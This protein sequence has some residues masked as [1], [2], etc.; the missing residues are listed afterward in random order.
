MNEL[1]AVEVKMFILLHLYH[2]GTITFALRRDGLW[3]RAT[4]SE[5]YA[6]RTARL[7]LLN[8]AVVTNE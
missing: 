3:H 8:L 2:A 6:S 1:Y 4:W 7:Q 5:K